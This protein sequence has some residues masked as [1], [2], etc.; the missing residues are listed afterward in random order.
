M[1]RLFNTRS[2]RFGTMNDNGCGRFAYQAGLCTKADVASLTKVGQT[3]ESCSGLKDV[4]SRW[5]SWKVKSLSVM[6]LVLLAS[7]VVWALGR[8]VAPDAVTKA[9]EGYNVYTGKLAYLT[10]GKYPGNDEA[11][12]I[13]QWGNKGILVFELPKP[14]LISEV[15][16]YVGEYAASYIV[17]FFLGATLGADGQSRDPEGERKGIVENYDYVTHQWVSLKPEAPMLAD[18]VQLET[19]GGPEMYEVEILVEEGTSIQPSSW[20]LVK[21]RFRRFAHQ[22]SK[23]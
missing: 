6:L 14:V 3:E 11:P 7:G 20:G 22:V 13:F 12:G 2:L 1:M 8:N 10:D 4:R 18:Y 9:T 16:L 23:L 5:S 21:S 17:T 19:M 15:R